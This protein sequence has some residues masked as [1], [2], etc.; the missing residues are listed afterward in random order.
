MFGT[1]YTQTVICL[2]GISH[3]KKVTDIP[4]EAEVV[5]CHNK[6]NLHNDYMIIITP[7]SP[8]KQTYDD[9]MKAIPSCDI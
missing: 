7:P 3:I 9:N 6:N 4:Y 2:S 1:L 8:F 5:L